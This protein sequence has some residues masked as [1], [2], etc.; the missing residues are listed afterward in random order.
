M[1]I[2]IWSDV[3]CP[4]CYIGKRRFESALSDFRIAHP[5]VE[6]EIAWRSFEL[7]PNAPPQRTEPMAE[8]LAKKYGMSV[9]R[10]REIQTQVSDAARD[11]GL[12]FHLDTAKSGNTFN[13]HRL[14]H[15]AQKA[16]LGDVM[17]ERLLKAYFTEGKAIGD[18]Q[19]ILALAEEVGLER[20]EAERALNDDAT[21][22]AVRED[23]ALAGELG[24]RGVPFFVIDRRLGI[25]G[26]QPPATFLQVLED[27]LHHHPGDTP[28]TTEDDA[29][30]T[31]EG[32]AVES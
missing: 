5:E 20:G 7:D 10:A 32:C 13:A 4:W 9:A 11:E 16:G 3:V 17:K 24:I 31:D 19:E 28:A 26:A 30:C 1:L 29:T 6:V 15:A 27:A 2:E 23:Q 22:R 25:S 18:P 21:S 12:T 14:I 8:H